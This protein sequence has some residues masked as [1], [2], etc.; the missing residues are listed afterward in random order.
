[1]STDASPGAA[2]RQALESRGWSQG[3]FAANIGATRP[4][5]TLL[6]HDRQR[7]TAKMAVR[8]AGAFGPADSESKPEYWLDKQRDWDLSR[9]RAEKE[10]AAAAVV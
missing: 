9:L 2:L 10:H 1:M 5:I 8:I 4:H 3:Q 7:I 6:V